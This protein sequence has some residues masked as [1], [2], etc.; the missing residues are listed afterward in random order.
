MLFIFCL[1]ATAA[2]PGAETLPKV[3]S[4]NLCADLLLLEIADPTQIVSVSYQ[5][6]DPRVSPVAD[7]ARAYPANRGAVEE[8]L[9]LKPEIALVYTGWTGRRHAN[10]LAG[11]GIEILATPYPKDWADTLSTVRKIAARIGRSEVG[12][13]KSAQAEQRM[14][15]LAERAR[16]Y[17]LLYLRPSGGTA[18]ANTYVDDVLSALGLRNHAAERGYSGWGRFPLEHLVN[19]PPDLILLGF[20]DQAQ[21]LSNSAYGRHPLFKKLLEQT[22]TISVPSNLWGCGGLELV[23][24]AEQIAAQIDG[25]DLDRSETR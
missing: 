20:F 16:P 25:L 3:A 8:L 24:A 19:A 7:I 12:E 1:T 15:K 9:Y 17:S 6:Q 21:A 14:R 5:S 18:G 13:A 2:S 22:P 23:V 10:L 4:T 11:Q